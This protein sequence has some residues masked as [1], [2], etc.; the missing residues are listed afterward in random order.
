MGI[1]QQEYWSGLPC[2]PPGDLPNPGIE[3][4]SPVLQVDSL[5]FKPSGKPKNT[6]VG[7]LSLLQGNFVTQESNQ[8][9]LHCRWILYQLSYQGRIYINCHINAE[10]INIIEIPGIY[11]SKSQTNDNQENSSWVT[12]L[13]YVFDSPLGSEEHSLSK[14]HYFSDQWHHCGSL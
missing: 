14:S 1:L 6:A 3:P 7:S 4:R 8:G 12:G 9:L 11:R 10:M 2:S 13:V 5:S